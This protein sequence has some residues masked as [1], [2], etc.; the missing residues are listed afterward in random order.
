M[1]SK[2]GTLNCAFFVMDQGGYGDEPLSLATFEARHAQYPYLTTPRSLEACRRHGINPVELVEVSID[3]F[4]KDFPDDPDAAQRRFDRIDGA[5]RRMLTTVLTEWKHLSDTGWQPKSK[6]ALD[7]E[8][9]LDVPAEAHSSMLE[10]QA[11]K[12]RKIEMDQWNALQRMLAMSVKNADK[13]QRDKEILQKQDAIGE[14]NQQARRNLQLKR[15]QLYKENAE[16]KKRKEYESMQ[17]IKRLQALDAEEA[18][19]KK[20]HDDERAREEKERREKR[21]SRRL[22]QEVY[23]KQ[24]KVSIMKTLEQKADAR[25]RLADMQTQESQARV[26][27]FREQKEAEQAARRKELADKQAKAKQD[28]QL[29][30]EEQRKAMLDRIRSDEEKRQRIKE[31]RESSR[32]ADNQAT[33]DAMRDKMRRIREANEVAERE[34]SAKA[35]A[36]LQFKDAL[37]KQELDKV[38]E[39]QEKRRGIKAIRQ[40]AYDLAAT[41][42]R[43]ADDY[44][45]RLAEKAIRDKDKKCLAIQNGFQTLTQMRTKMRDIMHSAKLQLKDE[46]HRLQHRDEFSPDKVIKVA[47]ETSSQILFPKYVFNRRCGWIDC[48][49]LR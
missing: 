24:L 36:D 18:V 4:R 26:R 8:R 45:K 49:R 6:L 48:M 1:A 11:A 41:R 22:Q 37:A 35:L 14:S 16:M 12:F 2:K 28:V 20:E 42:K 33:N 9:I 3:E 31:S 23:T 39:A 32:G 15:E 34:K 38:R 7:K 27:E 44:R 29:T 46:L 21:E 25:K 43:K 10:M 17:E 47:L 13:E 5:R 30:A 40:E 19:K